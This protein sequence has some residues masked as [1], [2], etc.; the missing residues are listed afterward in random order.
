V[1]PV[2]AITHEHDA[3]LLNESLCIGCKLCAIACPFGAI[4]PGGT[5]VDGVVARG[6]SYVSSAQLASREPDPDTESVHALP[7]LLQWACGV[8]PVAIKCDLCSFQAAGPECVRVCPTQALVVVAEPELAKSRETSK[9][10]QAVA[11]DLPASLPTPDEEA[12]S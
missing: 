7:P 8:R 9:M 12:T 10:Q 11:L 6:R 4:S 2:K 1:C 3:I 5:S